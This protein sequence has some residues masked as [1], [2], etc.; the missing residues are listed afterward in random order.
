ML[1]VMLKKEARNY[2]TVLLFWLL[3]AAMWV[4]VDIITAVRPPGCAQLSEPSAQLGVLD[5]DSEPLIAAARLNPLIQLF[6][7]SSKA[8]IA[9]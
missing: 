6:S 4:V 2:S 5:G 1:N 7:G 3:L 8:A 9:C